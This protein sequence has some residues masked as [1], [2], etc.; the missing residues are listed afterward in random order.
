MTE[1][2]R[3]RRVWQL[4]GIASFCFVALMLLEG[5]RV[6]APVAVGTDGQ[7]LWSTFLPLLWAMGM[8]DVFA[9]K[10]QTTELRPG[11]RLVKLDVALFLGAGVVAAAIFAQGVHPSESSL[12]GA[13]HA[14]TMSGLTVWMTLRR[15]PGAGMLAS[16]GLL[17]VTTLYGVHAPLGHYVR[18]LQPD[19]NPQ[20]AFL[21]GMLLFL[22]ALLTVC[23]DC[24]RTTN[25]FLLE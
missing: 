20:W 19:G 22:A 7:A 21:V 15:G 1:W 16:S 14:L 17:L 18:V 5:R 4:A 25:D 2:A 11:R 24:G 23:F 9:S 3:T 13:G 10:A 6:A 12:G 8:A